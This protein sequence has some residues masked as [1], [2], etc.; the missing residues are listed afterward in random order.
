MK[1]LSILLVLLLFQFSFSSTTF[2]EEKDNNKLSLECATVSEMMLPT[3]DIISTTV[4]LDFSDTCLVTLTVTVTAN[5]GS[6]TDSVTLVADN[7]PCDEVENTKQRLG[8][9]ARDALLS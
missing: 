7:V 9:Q 3:V 8:Q 6:Y 2:I 5:F 4:E 1:K